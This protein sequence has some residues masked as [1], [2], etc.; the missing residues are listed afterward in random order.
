M[1]FFFNLRDIDPVESCDSNLPS[2]SLDFTND[3]YGSARRCTDSDQLFDGFSS[4]NFAV[5]PGVKH[6]VG[7]SVAAVLKSTACPIV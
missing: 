5:H 7:E 6:A 2:A 3:P 4:C 1:C